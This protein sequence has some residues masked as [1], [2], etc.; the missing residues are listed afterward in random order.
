MNILHYL[1]CPLCGGGFSRNN[2]V[3]SCS[4]GHSFDLAKEG[5]VNLLPPGKGKNARTGD[6]KD[7]I[8]ARREFL[9]L[10]LYA[11]ISD[12]IAEL[13]A[14]YVKDDRETLLCDSGCGE[15]YHT[16]RITDALKDHVNGGILSVGFDA[17]KFAAACGMKAS[18]RAGFTGENGIGSE[19]NAL[20]YFLPANIF[21]LPLADGCVSAVISMFAPVAVQENLRVLK[22]DG[23][24]VTA[25]SG[26]G[27]LWEMRDLLYTDVHVSDGVVPEYDG[28][29]LAE[30]KK[31][32]YTVTLPDKE[33]TANLF[34][35]TP[36]Y[37][38]TTEA[39]RNRLYGVD[40]L[41]VTVDTDLRVYKR[42]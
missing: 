31:V 26:V 41:Q 9:A 25:S 30:E 39:G 40:S 17:S 12:G 32:C 4:A 35:M 13:L 3:L 16:L 10:G 23:I 36:F 7:M 18:A 14:G 15:G 6:E 20:A 11:P 27:H 37:Y 5:Y 42:K 19:G 24:L 29:S 34:T 2:N 33:A 8:R 38:K 21:S 22:D 1:R 28:F